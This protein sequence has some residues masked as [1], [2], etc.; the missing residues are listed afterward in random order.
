MKIFLFEEENSV[1]RF[2][3]IILLPGGASLLVAFFF[4]FLTK[5][6]N[7]KKAKYCHIASKICK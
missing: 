6:G 4:T 3:R 7:P 2:E 5:G 1:V